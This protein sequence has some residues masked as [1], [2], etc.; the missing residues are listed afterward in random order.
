VSNPYRK[1]GPAGGQT[2][3]AR[4][5]PPTPAGFNEPFW[6]G[7][8]QSFWLYYAADPEIV[9]ARLPDGL[10]VAL[11]ESGGERR[12]LASLDFQAYTG[13][14]PGYLEY[15]HEVEFNVYA[16][17]S[18]RV[19][20]VPML[21]YEEFLAGQD[22]TKSVGGYR[23][24]VPCDNPN[25]IKAGKGLY[26]EPKYL[27]QFTYSMPT[28]NDPTVVTWDYSVF[29][30]AGGQQGPL[31]YSVEA[32]LRGLTA[33]PAN[34]SPLTEYGTLEHDGRRHVV[35]NQWNF[36]GPFMTYL[37]AGEGSSRVS[38]GLGPAPDPEGLLG[39]LRELIGTEPPL[40]AQ[41]FTSP[42][43]ASECRG[44]FP[45]PA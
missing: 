29:Q 44:W 18:S 30:D 12:A 31:V 5:F 8:L 32:D 42:P 38:L 15:V 2:P 6:Y 33:L 10:E 27:A 37:L 13:H 20:E 9:A 16:Y 19:P 17:P 3:F 11:F 35:A 45:V 28:L 43:V 34:P 23:L 7:S 39:D 41:S 14:G 26:G 1:R 21:T 40:A 24:H 22:Q 36:Y 25:A 4:V